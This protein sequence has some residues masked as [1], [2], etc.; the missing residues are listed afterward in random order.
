MT[1]RKI[2]T[3]YIIAVMGI[4]GA[5]KS[6]FIN[7]LMGKEVVTVTPAHGPGSMNP[8][9]TSCKAVEVPAS[10]I[11]ERLLPCAPTQKLFIVDTPG[12]DN[13]GVRTSDI[14][15][16]LAKWLKESYPTAK[17]VG[18]IYLHDISQQRAT[19][20]PK[21]NLDK[22]KKMCGEKDFRTIVLGTTQWNATER[23]VAENREQELRNDLWKD[24][25]ASGS[26]ME[27]VD[28]KNS[29]PWKLV[30]TVL[31]SK[32]PVPQKTSSRSEFEKYQGSYVIPIMGPSG[33]GKSSFIN[34]LFGKDVVTVGHSLRSCTQ[35][36]Q[37][38]EVPAGMIQQQLPS[39]DP[40]G[41]KKL[42]IV[43]TP[44]FEDV[45]ANDSEILKIIT[46]WLTDLH[47]AGAIL[48]G[49]VYL[50]DITR[51]RITGSTQRNF[52]V[53]DKLCGKDACKSIVLGTTKW[54]KIPDSER[55]IAE[56]MEQHLQDRV[57]AGMVAKGSKVER[58]DDKDSSP[59][60]LVGAVLFE[61][62][63][64]AFQ[65]QMEMAQLAKELP[66]TEATQ[67][68]RTRIE[69]LINSL[70]RDGAS[71]EE[72]W[73]LVQELEALRGK[74]ILGR[75]LERFLEVLGRLSQAFV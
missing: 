43:D 12:F 75:L 60:K 26:K 61:G 62:E 29:S 59:W 39:W 27:R 69:E 52:D 7:Q 57:W 34:Q 66:K 55:K 46:K 3:D 65:I 1:R 49:A 67:A 37:L 4:T 22:L 47:G 24:M 6:S 41:T 2:T 72:V 73:A 10:V 17:L 16:I 15:G 40:A 14:P 31:K 54:R 30:E 21:Y 45:S 36:I 38:V 42:V 8:C 74:S 48:A 25:L 18:V 23:A 35:S 11:Q 70:K 64:P 13:P 19:G 56:N 71:K 50:E 53:F 44:G 51:A 68:L 32:P 58:V 20:I 33:A 28:D 63:L 9:T 5:G